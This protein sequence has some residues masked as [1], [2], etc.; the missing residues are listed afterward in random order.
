MTSIF[1]FSQYDFSLN[2]NIEGER[3]I[4]SKTICGLTKKQNEEFF[5][6]KNLKNRG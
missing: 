6:I 2:L 3:S 5:P 4:E 1:I